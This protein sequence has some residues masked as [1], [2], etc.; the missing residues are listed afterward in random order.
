MDSIRSHIVENST[1]P[2]ASL[3]LGRRRFLQVAAAVGVGGIVPQIGFA[4]DTP[5]TAP[6]T[7]APLRL[8]RFPQK[9]DLILLTDRPPNLETPLRHFRHDLT[10]NDAF[11]VRWHY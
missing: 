10:P 6:L 9:T 2:S 7:R 1:V 11:Y 3:K 4:A 5:A 8:A